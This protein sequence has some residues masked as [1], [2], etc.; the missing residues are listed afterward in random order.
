MRGC[1]LRSFPQA[2]GGG[3]GR[4]DSDGFAVS[5]WF[6]KDWCA[7]TACAGTICDGQ[8][9]G[10]CG[11]DPCAACEVQE[12]RRDSTLLHWGGP[13]ENDAELAQKLGQLQPFLA[14]FPQECMGQLASFG[15]T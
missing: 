13:S 12:E 5:L 6:Q 2:A 1:V 10:P 8:G 7:G 9:D 4:S 14:V 15:P 11:C 3:G